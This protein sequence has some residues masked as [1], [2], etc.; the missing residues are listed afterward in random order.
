MEA[1]LIWLEIYLSKWQLPWKQQNV[2]DCFDNFLLLVR[3]VNDNELQFTSDEF[4]KVMQNKSCIKGMHLSS[5]PAM[6]KQ[7]ELYI[8]SHSLFEQC[9]S[10]LV[11]SIKILTVFCYN[12]WNRPIWLQCNLQQVYIKTKKVSHHS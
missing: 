11:V 6:G 12:I 8:L 5:H 9:K 10:I 2:W 1:L 3:L 4:R 7:K